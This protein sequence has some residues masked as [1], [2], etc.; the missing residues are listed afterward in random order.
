MT[1]IRP[2]PKFRLRVSKPIRRKLYV[3]RAPKTKKRFFDNE[4]LTVEGVAALLWCSKQAVRLIPETELPRYRSP[5][6]YLLYLR[7]DVIA[8]LRGRKKQNPAADKLLREVEP[9]VLESASDSGR[10]R[11][12]KRRTS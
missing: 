3:L 1:T 8:Y 9:G 4:I 6:R 7:G 5:G 11:S 12:P 2:S 10:G